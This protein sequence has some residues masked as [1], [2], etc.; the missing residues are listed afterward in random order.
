MPDYYVRVLEM[1]KLLETEMTLYKDLVVNTQRVQDSAFVQI[2]DEQSLRMYEDWY[3]VLPEPGMT[4]DE[5]RQIV[6]NRIQTKL[7]F[8][9]DFLYNQMKAIYGEGNFGVSVDY[10]NYTLYLDVKPGDYRWY[11]ETQRIIKSIKPANLDFY[12][13]VLVGEYIDFLDDLEAFGVIYFR[14]ETDTGKVG[15]PLE[16]Y[17]GREEVPYDGS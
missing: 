9:L 15:M 8:S 3:R 5:R 7:P 2:C 4:L 17:Y 6:L 10:N 1:N 13:R 16:S 11:R 14:V 12:T